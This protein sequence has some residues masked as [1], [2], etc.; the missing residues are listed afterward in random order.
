M[1]WD[2]GPLLAQGGP[3]ALLTAVVWAIL[4][5]RLVPRSQLLREVGYRDRI[6]A[7]QEA[8]LAEREKQLGIV[9]GK[10]PERSL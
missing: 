4:T 3:S 7:A 10:L 1:P 9:I 6:I 8:T 2:I 5:G